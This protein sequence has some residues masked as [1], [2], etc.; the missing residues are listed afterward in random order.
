M[1]DRTSFGTALAGR[2]QVTEEL[3]RSVAAV[4]FGVAGTVRELGS[5]QDRNFLVEAAGRRYVLKVANEAFTDDELAAQE[6]A[7]EH[8]ARRAPELDLPTGVRAAGGAAV[9]RFD[10]P[11]GPLRARLLTFVPGFPLGE[12]D[13]LAPVVVAG[14]G[15]VAGQVAAGLAD[16]D[17]PGLDRVLQWDVR[18]ARA[19]CG[20]LAP[21]LAGTGRREQV[22]DAAARACDVLDRLAPDLRVQ[23]VHGD[24][25]DDNVVCG[26]GPDGRPVPTGVIDFGD[27][28][29]GWVVGDLAA[30]CASV[31]HHDPDRPLA[32]L[33]AVR[34]YDRHVPLSDAELEALW[35]A[36]VA[37]AAVLVVS[38]VHQGV[39][40]PGN[41]YAVG[42]QDREWQMLAT[43]LALPAAVV[44]AAL[45]DALG[46][47]RRPLVT[48]PTRSAIPAV[49]GLATAGVLDLSVTS[50]DLHDGGWLAPGAQSRLAAAALA[51][52]PA[53]VTTYGEA[54]LTRTVPDSRLAPATVA[55]GVEVHVAPGTVVRA[56]LNGVL[57]ASPGGCVLACDGV[58]LVIRGVTATAPAG[59]RVAVG[60]QVGLV[61]GPGAAW[62]QLSALPGGQPPAYARPEEAAA[63]QQVCPDPSGLLG[64][65]PAP[66]PMSAGELLALRRSS[67]AGVQEHYFVEP[68]RIERGWRHHLVDTGGRTYLDAVNNVAAVGHAHP[69]VTAAAARQWDL[70]NTNSRFHYA[71]L[72]EFSAR[73]AALLP[74]PLDTVFLVN[75][76]SEAVDLALRLAQTWTGRE[77]VVCLA[78]AYHGWTVASD[79]VSTSLADNPQALTTRPAWVHPLPAPNPFRGRFRGP[80][81]APL[82]IAD[83][84]RRLADVP[85]PAALLCEA[86]YGNAGGL[87]LP[88]GYLRALYAA[89]RAAGGLC[90]ADEVQV[91]YGRLGASFW[92][93]EQ[94]GV[95]PDVVT[96][97]KAM[98]NGHP[99]GAVVTRRDVAEAFAR[100]GYFFSSAGGSPVSCAV[101]SAVLDVIEDEHLQHN[102]WV[103]GSH[104]RERFQ[105]LIGTVPLVGAVHGLG[106]YLGV[107]LVK[108]LETFEPATGETAAVCERLLELGVVLQPTGDR[109]NILKVKP[110]MCLTLA[111]ADVL[112]DRLTEVLTRGW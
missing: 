49:A 108:D 82:W 23:A 15:A 58:D 44:T 29:L 13:H 6:A 83:A 93:F 36:V 10:G 54:R 98:G 14:L 8:L 78:E 111:A 67:L 12:Q 2:P 90:I 59:G 84:L 5:Q 27:V 65:Q 62:F 80:G 102:A 22:L 60:D 17:V 97:A 63:W 21:H 53:A 95:V 69:R 45:R 26:R 16:L 57:V 70:L 47:P 101:G 79:A 87:A 99:L 56:P 20:L 64:V 9:A 30:T 55:L 33:P 19:V 32:V 40:D 86:V 7:L 37:R 76:G 71:A 104:L 106:L 35:P 3:A 72:P 4:H 68:P 105:A 85:L 39:V 24:V 18:R 77:D 88:D 96:V 34:G 66:V 43:A 74:E 109:L 107:E 100:N 103:V 28:A 31:L 81:S 61:T 1:S 48:V 46:R 110:P 112:V 92:G 73:L 25:T 94:Q 50:G 42:A 38:G 41:A 51:C 75:S 52:A 11:D 91:G 89:T